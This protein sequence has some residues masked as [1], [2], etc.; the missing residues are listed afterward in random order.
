MS[1][2]SEEELCLRRPV[3]DA[4]SSLFLDTDISIL[5][6]WRAEQ[7]ADSPYT[8]AQLEAILVDEVYPI[9]RTNLLSIAGEWAGFDTEW[10][11]ARIVRRLRSPFRFLHPIN[12]GRLT[13]HL[14]IEWRRTKAAVVA[15]RATD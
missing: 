9:C 3:W 7:L 12:L 4:L 8:L 5:R 11:E 13:V 15:Y 1:P 14:S 6:D 10:L 2:F